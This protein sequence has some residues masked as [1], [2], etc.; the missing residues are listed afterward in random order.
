MEKAIYENA[1]VLWDYMHMHMD[2]APSQ[3]ILGFGSYDLETA[4][5]CAELWHQGW[6]PRIL[7]TGGLGRNTRTMYR[8]SEACRYRDLA[9][10]LGVPE[11]AIALETEASNTGENIRFSRRLLEPMNVTDILAV[12]KPFMERRIHA[13]L[14]VCWPE[15]RARVTSPQ[16]SLTRYIDLSAAQGMPES[17]VLEILTGDF[18]RLE[19]YAER[20]YQLPQQIPPEARRAFEYLKAAG[21]TRDLI[22]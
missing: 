10:S 4:R 6:A 9:V 17:R 12:G 18:Q 11:S 5:R 3:W 13:A 15:V 2:P 16:V 14:G 19:V 1:L 22:P 20:G 8:R 7:F 21:Y